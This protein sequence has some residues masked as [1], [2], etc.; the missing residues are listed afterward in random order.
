[1]YSLFQA[2]IEPLERLKPYP[3]SVAPGSSIIAVVALVESP[4]LRD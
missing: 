4:F 3:L 1:V 2:G